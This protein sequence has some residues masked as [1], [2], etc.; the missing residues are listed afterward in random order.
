MGIGGFGETTV[1]T[2]LWVHANTFRMNIIKPL[3][4]RIRPLLEYR[5]PALFQ[6]RQIIHRKLEIQLEFPWLSKK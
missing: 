1:L 3:F 2:P 4:E 5:F 6:Q